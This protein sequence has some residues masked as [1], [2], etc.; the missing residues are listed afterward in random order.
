MTLVRG[1][2]VLHYTS[3]ITYLIKDVFDSTWSLTQVL[4]KEASK[5]KITSPN[6]LK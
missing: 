2:T 3:K 6:S 4:G 5:I 1:K